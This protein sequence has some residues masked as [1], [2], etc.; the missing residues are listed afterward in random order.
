M[1]RRCWPVVPRPFSAEMCWPRRGGTVGLPPQTAG[2]TRRGRVRCVLEGRGPSRP[3]CALCVDCRPRRSVV[4]AFAGSCGHDRG[5]A[6]R[7]RGHCV[8]PTGGRCLR[9]YLH[10][11]A[12]VSQKWKYPGCGRVPTRKRGERR[13]VAMGW[14][15]SRPRGVCSQSAARWRPTEGNSGA[16]PFG[17]RVVQ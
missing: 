10:R 11:I 12:W 6:P 5:V 3:S 13:R 17:P 7:T 14:E 2:G 9:Q 15:M 8:T 4:L 1:G 16:C